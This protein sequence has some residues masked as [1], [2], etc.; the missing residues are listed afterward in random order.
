MLVLLLRVGE[1]RFGLDA[2]EV[3]EIVPAIPLTPLPGAPA[4]LAGLLRHRQ[5]LVP[6]VDLAMLVRGTRAATR[7]STRIIVLGTGAGD[8]AVGLLAEGVTE[9]IHVDPEGL[10]GAG[11][12]AAAPWVGPI[13][14]ADGGTV[15]LVRWN[16]LIPDAVRALLASAAT[17]ERADG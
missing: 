14:L 9:T 4:W 17:A 16:D 8:A 10:H 13:A 5:G 7:L 2:R 12:T 6:V 1:R 11:C 3:D 15:Q